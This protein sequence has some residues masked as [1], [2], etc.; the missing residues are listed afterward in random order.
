MSELSR[1]ADVDVLV[2]GAGPTG[3][4]LAAE[5]ARRD[6]RVRIIDR[7]HDR[8][9]E[10]RALAIQPRTLEV[11]APL[12]VTDELIRRGNPAVDVQIH[13]P[14]KVVR[15]PLFD[16]GATDTRYPFLLFLSQAET[17]AVL[18]Q[19]LD[20][21]G[22]RLERGLELVSFEDG[23][24][25]VRCTV[26]DESGRKEVIEAQYVVGCD[27]SRSAVRREAGISFTGSAYPQT[28][29]LADLE[30]DGIQPGAAHAFLGGAGM[31]FFFPLGRPTT[32][33]M[34]AMRPPGQSASD[35]DT[36][37]LR[38]VQALADRYT[39][40]GVRLRD[41][42]WMTNFRLHNRG[43]SQYRAGRAFVAGDAAHV[44]SPAGA[45]GMNT[46]IQDAVNLAWKL[47]LVISGRGAPALLDTYES[48]RAPIGRTVLRFTDRAF[49]IA[50]STHA[51]VVFARTRIA[52][53]VLPLLV[54]IRVGRALAFRT[55]SEIAIR[56]RRSPLSV[57]GHGAVGRAVRAGDRLPDA[58]LTLDGRP[59]TLHEAT[60]GRGFHLIVHGPAD[61]ACLGVE[62]SL[63][64]GPGEV[65]F[66]RLSKVA[67]PHVLHDA[68]GWAHRLLGVDG[69]KSGHLLV[70]PD[71][72]VAYR[73]G[74]DL[75]GVRE[76][77]D[78]WLMH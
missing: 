36:V 26:R 46:G 27:G 64:G 74:G 51:A 28:F 72:Y 15:V 7:R 45:Q 50:T 25:A 58:P 14:R 77:L 3:L 8:V 43:A 68:T 66:H 22:V 75:T 9:H 67:A 57:D 52:P 38:E 10:S 12:G 16:I 61:A 69:F 44:H 24:D 54:R 37:E 60:A 21:R 49:T 40:G 35:R 63:G 70:R 2:V 32:W 47:A 42:V 73:G 55:I 48:E 53:A 78:D 19:D 33:R 30:A 5:L 34:L 11:L 13:F 20:A 39:N 59:T 23:D 4:T 29:V 62:R 18:G 17:E 71:G 6:V 76:Y 41:P 1:S 56:Y 31:L 65:A